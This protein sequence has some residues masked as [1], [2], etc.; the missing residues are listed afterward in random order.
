MPKL[1]LLD[2][3]QNILSA[4]DSDEVNSIFDTVESEQVVEILKETYFELL[5]LREWPQK[6]GIVTLTALS[7]NNFP[8]FF[9][10]PENV[11]RVEAIRYNGDILVYLHPEEFLD[12]SLS[13]D[14]TQA[15]VFEGTDKNSGKPLYVRNDENP[16]YWTSFDDKYVIL[17]SYDNTVDTTLQES[18]ILCTGMKHPAW[19]MDDTFIP[20]MP[21]DYFP[22]LLAE[23]KSVA[24]VNLKQSANAKEEQRAKRQR[25]HLQKTEWREN[26]KHYRQTNYGRK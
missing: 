10:I 7:D 21:I 20:D 19:T 8:T 12:I 18:K 16:V 14:T 13:L 22:M 23:A 5:S 3:T 9:E 1:T 6:H 4:M 15:N 26:G 11:E 25:V 17:N 24:F 2:M